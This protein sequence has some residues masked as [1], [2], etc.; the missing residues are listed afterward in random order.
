MDHVQSRAVAIV[1][2]PCPPGGGKVAG[3]LVTVTSQRS[4]VGADGAVIDVSVLLQALH[5]SATNATARAAPA[6]CRLVLIRLTVCCA[7][8]IVRQFG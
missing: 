1:T 6:I 5:V 8:Q 2:A 3:L 4:V 7:S